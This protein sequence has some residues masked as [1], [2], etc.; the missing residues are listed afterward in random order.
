[1]GSNTS[2]RSTPTALEPWSIEKSK[3]DAFVASCQS[4]TMIVAAL[5]PGIMLLVLTLVSGFAWYFL[6]GN[7][8]VLCTP[9]IIFAL[10]TVMMAAVTYMLPASLIKRSRIWR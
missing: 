4:P 6:A 2:H 5:M 1:M 9:A 8:G 10:V 7:G 3:W